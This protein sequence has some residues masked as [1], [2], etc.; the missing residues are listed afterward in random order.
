MPVLPCKKNV[1]FF[2]TLLT[3]RKFHISI[4]LKA[5]QTYDSNFIVLKLHYLSISYSKIIFGL[6]Y[7]IQGQNQ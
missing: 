1:I 2:S 7:K 5:P 4:I 6:I 3:G